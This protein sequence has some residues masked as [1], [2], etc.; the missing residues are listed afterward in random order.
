MIYSVGDLIIW[1]STEETSYIT[2]TW[3]DYNKEVY[4]IIEIYNSQHKRYFTETISQERI[5]ILINYGSILH[6]PVR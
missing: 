3:I 5:S 2:G 4:Y 6:Y 1:K